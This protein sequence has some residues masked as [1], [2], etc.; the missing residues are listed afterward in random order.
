[1]GRGENFMTGTCSILNVA[2]GDIEVTFDNKN[3]HS[4]HDV[5]LSQGQSMGWVKDKIA[6]QRAEK[7]M[8]PSTWD[9]MRD[10]IGQAVNEFNAL[11]TAPKVNR[12]DCESRAE[13]CVRVEKEGAAP[14]EIFLSEEDRVILSA[15]R[16]EKPVIVC[17]YRLSI[18]RKSLD[19]FVEDESGTRKII[20]AEQACCLALENYLFKPLPYG[21]VEES[22]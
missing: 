5:S 11:V 17:R 13:Y 16:S 19:L 12:K 8:I 3:P 10:A 14:K 15:Q 6:E 20:T 1:M 4:K 9:A 21:V 2:G 18:D 22:L 7:A